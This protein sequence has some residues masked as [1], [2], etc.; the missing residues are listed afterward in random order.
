M[1]NKEIDPRTEKALDELKP[2]PPRNPV[3]AYRGKVNFLKQAADMR[4]AVS[5]KQEVRH[6]GR[7]NTIFPAFPRK[8]RTPVFNTFVAIV[9]ALTVFLGGTA[10]TVYASQ[11][12]LPNQTLYPV[13][14]WSE[15]ARLSLTGSPQA[16]MNINLDL[17]DQRITEMTRMLADG[18]PIPLEVMTRLQN[19]LD[20]ALELA[21]GM[22]DSQML[23]QL[24]QIRQRAETQLQQTNMLMA[25][26]TEFAQPILLQTQT[27]LQEQV[28]LAALGQADPQGFRLQV[29]QRLQFQGGTGEQAPGTGNRQQSPVKTQTPDSGGNG[30]DTGGNSPT[31]T[32][33]QYGPGTGGSSPTGTPGQY[34]PGTGGSSP[35]GTPGQYG[36]GTNMPQGTPQPGGGSGNKP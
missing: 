25:G 18:N 11:D 8:E 21:A 23:Q 35:T 29:K 30:S 7:I 36:T 31:G 24:E 14:I 34:G 26:A 10:T 9:I 13:K 1:R 5:R 28:Q 22:E 19:E 27:R 20:R 4:A 2:V 15:D 17:T 16:Q 33:G 3:A 6:N 12:S 32:P